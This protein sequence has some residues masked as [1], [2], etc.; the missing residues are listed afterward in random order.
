MLGSHERIGS[1]LQVEYGISGDLPSRT[2]GQSL[3][4]GCLTSRVWL[5]LRY[6]WAAKSVATS[7][8]EKVE[9]APTSAAAGIDSIAFEHPQANLCPCLLN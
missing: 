1:S 3:A 7:A 8:S 6:Q 2:H 4:T 5:N 9:S